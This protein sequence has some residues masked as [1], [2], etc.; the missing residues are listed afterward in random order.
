LCVC[1]LYALLFCSESKLW[2]W[3]WNK[4]P[5]WNRHLIKFQYWPIICNRQ[6]CEIKN[7]PFNSAIWTDLNRLFYTTS[8]AKKS[9]EILS[10]QTWST[11]YSDRDAISIFS[12]LQAHNGIRSPWYITTLS[13]SQSTLHIGSM[14]N[15]QDR[16]Q[17]SQS[18]LNKMIKAPCSL[19]QLRF[20]IPLNIK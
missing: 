20:Y 13:H 19:T 6:L 16:R 11:I 8:A 18:N 9:S 14:M 3:K 12:F 4:K 17:T 2:Q 7:Y 15:H 1:I 10:L 5:N